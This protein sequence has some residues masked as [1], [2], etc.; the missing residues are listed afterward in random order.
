MVLRPQDTKGTNMKDVQIRRL[1]QHACDVNNISELSGGIQHYWMEGKRDIVVF[2]TCDHNGYSYKP[3]FK[4]WRDSFNS[5]RQAQQIK[6]ILGVT[7][8]AIQMY[9]ERELGKPRNTRMAARMLKKCLRPQQA[10]QVA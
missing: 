4:I 10:E 2:A 8:Q 5:L 6:L 7:C 3:A 1:I 9:R